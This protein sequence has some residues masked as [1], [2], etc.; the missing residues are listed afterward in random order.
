MS[1]APEWLVELLAET[2]R[3]D[4]D[5]DGGLYDCACEAIGWPGKRVGP[6]PYAD[7]WELWHAHVAEVVWAGCREHWGDAIPTA[8]PDDPHFRLPWND[9]ADD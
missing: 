8:A 2:H 7:G 6:D 5:I 3:P 1:E 9:E 4:I